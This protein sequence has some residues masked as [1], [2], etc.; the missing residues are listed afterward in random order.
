MHDGAEI[1]DMSSK[2]ER[3]ILITHPIQC[4]TAKLPNEFFLPVDG[5][6]HRDMLAND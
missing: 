3:L 6:C 2:P 1:C 4:V 5:A